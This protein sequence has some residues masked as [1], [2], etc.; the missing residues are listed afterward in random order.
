[1]LIPLLH[2]REVF[3]LFSLFDGHLYLHFSKY[4]NMYFLY[5]FFLRKSANHFMF[6]G[7]NREI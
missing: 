3:R 5:F 4:S 1:M 7:G 2:I 6:A